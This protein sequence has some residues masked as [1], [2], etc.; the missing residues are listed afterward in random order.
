MNIKPGI[1]L[2][3]ETPGTGRCIGQGDLVT[4]RLQ[5]WLN[6]GEPIQTDYVTTVVVGRRALI[7]GIE[8]SLVGMCVGGSRRVQISPHL[9]YGEAGIPGR[10]PPR[11]ALRY[12]I[13]VLS[14]Q[15]EGPD[16]SEGPDSQA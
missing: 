15:A 7:P 8:Y 4:I 10:I 14:A 11:A 6:Q 12:D 9:A 5:G 13:E 1:R 2:L 16:S 3:A